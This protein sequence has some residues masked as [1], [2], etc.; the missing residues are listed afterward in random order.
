LSLLLLLSDKISLHNFSLLERRLIIFI[1][2]V[3]IVSFAINNCIARYD[4]DIIPIYTILSISFPEPECPSARTKV[5][6]NQ[7]L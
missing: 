2:Y 6:T 5:T 7:S 1:L 3:Y 4:V